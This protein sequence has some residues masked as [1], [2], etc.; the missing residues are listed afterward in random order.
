MKDERIIRFRIQCADGG[1]RFAG[2]GYD[3]WFDLDMARKIVNYE[4]G[5]RIIESDG[6]NI[7]WEIL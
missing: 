1:I 7:L 2:T 3:S 4:N 6:I 5:E